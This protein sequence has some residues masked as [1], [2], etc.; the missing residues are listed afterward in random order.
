MLIKK[1][2]IRNLR[3]YLL[4]VAPNTKIVIA[5]ITILK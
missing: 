2:R 1:H 4:G 5:L 3:R